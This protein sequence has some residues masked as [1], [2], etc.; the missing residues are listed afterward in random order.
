MLRPTLRHEGEFAVLYNGSSALLSK[1]LMHS[2]HHADDCEIGRI[3]PT[4][5]GL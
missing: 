5:M 2:C 1:V 4:S 3:G